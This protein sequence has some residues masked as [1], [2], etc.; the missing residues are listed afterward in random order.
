M[1][2]ELHMRVKPEL[3]CSFRNPKQYTP[4]EVEMENCIDFKYIYECQTQSKH[5]QY[6]PL[7]GSNTGDSME[8]FASYS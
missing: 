7:G 2:P 4:S 3:K 1:C 5:L 8:G 6:L